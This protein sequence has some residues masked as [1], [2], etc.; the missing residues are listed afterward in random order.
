MMTEAE[1]VKATARRTLRW[2]LIGSSILGASIT[3]VFLYH[4]PEFASICVFGIVC[5]ICG[6]IA[7][8]AAQ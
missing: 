7:G 8:T 3:A 5:Y 1:P 4:A 2:R 6:V